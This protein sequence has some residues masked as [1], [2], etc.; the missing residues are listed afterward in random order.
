V[1]RA[2]DWRWSSLHARLNPA[3]PA[4]RLVRLH[5]WPVDEPAD[6]LEWVNQPQTAQEL[7]A[8]RTSVRRGRPFGD[9][10]WQR[11]TAA[12]LGLGHSLRPLGRP[13]KKR[14]DAAAV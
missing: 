6:W 14:A 10:P 13:C 12:A 11:Q 2:Q 1:Q 4:A 5:P 8:L 7:E 9:E 3:S